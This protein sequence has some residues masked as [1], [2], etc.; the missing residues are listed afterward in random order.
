MGEAPVAGSGARLGGH[1]YNFAGLRDYKDKFAP[2]WRSRYLMTWGGID[3][4][5]VANDV[6]ALVS[7]GLRG[8]ITRGAKGKEDDE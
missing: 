8:A 7:G 1:F 3:P 6:T 2:D 5:L 4:L